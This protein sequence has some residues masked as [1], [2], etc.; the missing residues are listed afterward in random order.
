M[1][2][3]LLKQVKTLFSRLASIKNSLKNS[4]QICINYRRIVIAYYRKFV[5]NKKHRRSFRPFFSISDKFNL[6]IKSSISF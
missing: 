3:F 2:S 4:V 6:E 5:S 1:L